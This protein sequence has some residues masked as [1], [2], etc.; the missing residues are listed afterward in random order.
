MRD[1]YTSS[2]NPIDQMMDYAEKLKENGIDSTYIEENN[3][4]LLKKDATCSNMKGFIGGASFVFDNKFVLFGDIE[5][6]ESKEKIKEHIKKYNL[7]L[8][9]FKGPEVHDYGGAIEY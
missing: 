6:L 5:K 1:D 7:Q 3:I 8:I 9:D 2:D 4:R